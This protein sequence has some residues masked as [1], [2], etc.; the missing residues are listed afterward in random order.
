MGME[1]KNIEQ[2]LTNSI[3]DHIT[4]EEQSM[5]DEWIA[6]SPKNKREAEAYRELWN[7]SKK[8][9]YSDAINLD[10]ELA[11][12]K[13][14]IPYFN[15]R[16][17]I[18]FIRQAAAV[19]LLTLSLTVVFQYYQNYR[20]RLANEQLGFM[21]V[22]TA[23]GMQS[24]FYLP[25]GTEVWLNSGSKLR[26]PKSFTGNET[27]DIE[28]QGEAF[29]SVTKDAKHPFIVKTRDIDIKVLGTEFNVT[30]YD[31][32]KSMTVAL[33]SGKV[34]V[35]RNTADKSKEL[36]TLNPNEIMEYNRE[37]NRFYHIQEKSLE[38]YT[39]WKRGV[40]MFYGDPAETV[41]HR[42]EKWYN[43]EIRLADPSIRQYKFTATFENESLD[44][45]LQYLSMSTP[46]KYKTLPQKMNPDHS[47]S[48]RVIVISNK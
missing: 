11:K 6:A 1:D 25:D 5:L 40:M 4:S 44:Q 15:Q 10:R 38:K 23:Y 13:K 28:L 7:K 27:R 43:V 39:A 21:E 31:D 2:I 20:E 16:K 42:L 34:S 19:L 29:F 17:W 18:L 46:L 9:V 36:L 41:V 37:E 48:K 45:V 3:L 24:S 14:R 12:T 22:K 47:F 30:A 32:F 8:L 35:L 33:E 26:Y